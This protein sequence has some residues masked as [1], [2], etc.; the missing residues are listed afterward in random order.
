MDQQ[1]FDEQYRLEHRH[2]DGSWASME[3]QRS[4]HDAADHDMERGWTRRRIFKCATCEETATVVPG[5]EGG[6]IG[7]R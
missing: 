7:P 3:E 6:A 2:T 4:H 5:D 1:R